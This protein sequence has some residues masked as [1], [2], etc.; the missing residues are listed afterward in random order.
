MPR[1]RRTGVRV[2]AQRKDWDCGVAALAML[3]DV[4]YGDVAATCRALW[5]ST[6]PAKRGLGLYHMEA[7]AAEMGRPFRRV[8]K[9]GGYLVGETGI[10]GLVGGSMSWAGHWVV[11]KSGPTGSFI[12]EPTGGEAW[13]VQ[14]YLAVTK[15]RTATLLVEDR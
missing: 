14:D 15:S 8:Y 6:R 5:G 9:S 7:L 2:L 4:P 12:C 1:K 3:F 13:D 10:L 11:L